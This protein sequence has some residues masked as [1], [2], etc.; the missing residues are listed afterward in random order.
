MTDTVP[1]ISVDIWSDVMCPWCAIGYSQFAKAVAELNGEIEVE[2]RWMPFELNP[3]MPEA[4][5]PQA[6]HLAEV[7]GRSAEELAD[8]RANLEEAARR[9]GFSMDYTGEGTAPEPMMWNT[10]AAHRLLRWALAEYGPAAQT[11]LKLALF[12]AHFQARRNVSDHAVLLDL[13]ESEGMDR[14]AAQAALRDDALATAV[15]MEEQRSAS[16]GIR[17][18]PAFVFNDRYLVPGAQ[19][20]E[21]FGDTIRKIVAATEADQA[22]PG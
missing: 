19:T 20:P 13:V 6:Q 10:F 9:A 22:S 4:G 2:T 17:S 15:R 5:K 16:A 14:E 7:Y 11:G 12:R 1:L 3:D 21:I 18:V 8:M